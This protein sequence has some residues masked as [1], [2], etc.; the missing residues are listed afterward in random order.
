[1]N[2]ENDMRR[3]AGTPGPLPLLL[4]CT[5][6]AGYASAQPGDVGPVTDAVYAKEC[7]SCHMAYPAG[8]LPER[9]WNRVM[10]SLGAHFGDIA[11]VKASE[12]QA[13]LNYLHAN[14]ADR[15]ANARSREIAASIPAGAAPDRITKTPLI[16]GI[17]G[18]L[19]DPKFKGV[20]KVKSLAECAAC[21]PRANDGRF[22]ERRY[23]ITDEAFRRPP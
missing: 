19:L 13:I 15:V 20:P 17:H 4:A 10:G 6:F 2:K 8:L 14:A 9:S 22:A 16:D 18:G 5:L 1:M 7:G 11:E 3:M 21:H 12:R 23:V